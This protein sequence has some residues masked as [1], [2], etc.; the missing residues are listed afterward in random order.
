MAKITTRASVA[1]TKVEA[2]EGTVTAV[3]AGTDAI[4]LQPDFA[5]T[6]S[7]DYLE[8]EEL[9][10]SI[11]KAKQIRGLENPSGSISH[12]LRHSGVEGQEPN[13]GNLLYS[14]FGAKAVAGT[15]YDTVSSSTTSVIKVNTGEGANYQRGQGLLI[16]DETNGY[17][18]R[19][20]HSISTDDL[21]I[22]F[23]VPN[24]P[25]SGVNLGKCVLYKPVSVD[26]PTLSIWHY[27]GNGGGVQL[28][29]GARVTSLSMDVAAGD[30][31]NG[32]FSFEGLKYYFNPITI[33]SADRY[34]DWTDD[35][36]TW[37]AAITAKTY[38]D[39]HELATALT[40][41]MNGQSTETITVVYLDATGKFKITSTGT[42]LSLL[43]NSG[44]NTANTIGDKIGFSTAADDTGT[45]AATGYQS[46][47]AQTY[48]FPYTV[49]LDDADPIPAK[50]HEIMLG[51]SDDYVCFESKGVSVSV[52]Q[53]RSPTPSI[54]AET[55]IS[56]S[57]ISERATEV[58]VTAYLQKYDA[59]Q[60]RRFRENTDTRFQY[61]FG[62]KSS[63]N[64]VAGKC[65]YW[66]APTANIVEF[67]IEDEDG[68][69]VLKL[70]LACAIDDSG[71]P[72][73]YHGYV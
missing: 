53:T 56:G 44:T 29:T 41:A 22:G 48:A 59:D 51:D 46:D 67:S 33:A 12:Y 62:T 54:C 47:N 36:G 20:V 57:I 13:F 61:S 3:A 43:W 1:A 71:N 55:G 17:R 21:T 18:I 15:E 6:P 52:E 25:A 27:L 32:S 23:Q 5:V 69:A 50:N 7:V 37:A 70:K 63:G 4:A 39:P 72:E 2:S 30:L 26:H 65:G 14:L 8:N 16:K 64:W 60:F 9:R 45:A 19:A 24:A 34:I 38:A 68:I 40:E 73:I 11:G 35:D 49:S 31:I 42:V 28:V 58:N 10:A 66:Y